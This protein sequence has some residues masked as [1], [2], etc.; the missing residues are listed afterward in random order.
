MSH[1]MRNHFNASRGVVGGVIGSFG[2]FDKFA[3]VK[4]KALPVSK[5]NTEHKNGPDSDCHCPQKR[6][7]ILETGC[8]T[9]RLA[10][11]GGEL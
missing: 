10:V 8:L 4:Y 2:S 9:L 1:Y 11:A 6:T 5:E 3:H 7:Y